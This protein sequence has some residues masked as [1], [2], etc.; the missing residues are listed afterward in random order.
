MISGKIA[1]LKRYYPLHPAFEF[2]DKFLQEYMADPKPDGSYEILP[3]RLTAGIATNEM[4]D[5]QTKD[6]EAHKKFA[7][8]QVI[9]KGTERIDWADLDTCTEMV[10]EEYSKG[11]D[12][13]FYKDPEFVS[14]VILDEGEFMIMFPEDAHKPCV[15]PTADA[16]QPVTKIVFKVLL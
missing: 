13:A 2:V 10:S 16:S 12:I 5:A 3:G 4:A 15:K 1:D 7:D 11:G 9:M 14:K 8:V 6:F